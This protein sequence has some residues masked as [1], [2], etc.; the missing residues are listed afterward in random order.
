MSEVV[1]EGHPCPLVLEED[2]RLDL[3]PLE[4]QPATIVIQ[5]KGGLVGTNG[6]TGRKWASLL[7][8][9]GNPADLGT[10]GNPLRVTGAAIQV[11]RLLWQSQLLMSQ[12]G[13]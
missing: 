5:D 13:R 11:G 8:V 10:T 4:L 9:L 3:S 7:Q 12:T 6:C 2:E 1:V